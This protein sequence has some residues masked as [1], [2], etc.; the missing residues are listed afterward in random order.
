MKLFL[1]SA[2]KIAVY[3]KLRT[4][5]RSN[6]EHKVYELCKKWAIT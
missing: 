4:V 5:V 2:E 3:P 1:I 6:A